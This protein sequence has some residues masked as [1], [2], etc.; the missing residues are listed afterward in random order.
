MHELKENILGE[1]D[2]QYFSSWGP[3]ANNI[4]RTP[5]PQPSHLTTRCGPM[6]SNPIQEIRP[7]AVAVGTHSPA[8]FGSMSGRVLDRDWTYGYEGSWSG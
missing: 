7:R 8:V 2:F 4:T 3:N 6:Q 5:A 1:V